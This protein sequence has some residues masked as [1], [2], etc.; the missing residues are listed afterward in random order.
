MKHTGKGEK[1]EPAARIEERKKKNQP[2]LYPPNPAPYLTDWFLEI[3]PTAPGGMGDAPI[4]WQDMAAWSQVTGIELDPWEGRTLRRL[5][6][7]HI[8]QKY[9]A[10]KPG[11]IEPRLEADRAKAEEVSRDRVSSQFAAMVKALKPSP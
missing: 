8:N 6:I 7:A 2:V 3:G 4:S 1:P 5:S 10:K 11:C 9:A